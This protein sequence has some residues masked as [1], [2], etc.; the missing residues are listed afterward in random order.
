MKKDTKKENVDFF[1]QN[2]EEYLKDPS[3]KHK[4]VVI[5]EKELK[6]SFDSFSAALEFASANF[7]PTDFVIQQVIGIDE[8]INFIKSAV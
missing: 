7:S 2:L 1:Q 8:Q 5:A 6:N 3:L 4:Y